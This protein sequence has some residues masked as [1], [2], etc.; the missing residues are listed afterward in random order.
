M[1]CDI[2][3]GGKDGKGYGAIYVGGKT[4]LAHRIVWIQENGHT[5]Q[6]ILHSCDTPACVNIEHLRPGT[7]LENARDRDGRSRNG[8][9]NKTHCKQGHPFD[10][11]NTYIKKTGARGCRTC[12]RTQ[13]AKARMLA[14]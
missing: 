8:N 4:M 12:H 2:W 1:D 10:E 13:V 14:V 9:K 11:A 7:H 6:I 5:D 3:T